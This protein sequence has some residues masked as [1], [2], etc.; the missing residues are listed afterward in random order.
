MVHTIQK[1]KPTEFGET[2][3]QSPECRNAIQA[4]AC[5]GALPGHLRRL[6]RDSVLNNTTVDRE[7]EVAGTEAMGHLGL[8]NEESHGGGNYL[9]MTNNDFSWLGLIAGLAK[10]TVVTVVGGV[11][12]WFLDR[13]LARKPAASQGGEHGGSMEDS[14]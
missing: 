9:V 2:L 5:F 3:C 11:V 12:K 6:A 13:K 10:A 7:T 4:P 1:P 14:K 8:G